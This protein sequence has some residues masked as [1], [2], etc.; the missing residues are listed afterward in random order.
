M[1]DRVQHIPRSAFRVPHSQEAEQ[2]RSRR[3][4]KE[5]G[6]NSAGVQ[7]ILRLRRQVVELQGRVHQLE[8]DLKTEQARSEARFAGYRREYNEAIW[9]RTL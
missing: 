1:A 7:V 6:I 4:V 3:L 5:L 8:G 9:E 2:R